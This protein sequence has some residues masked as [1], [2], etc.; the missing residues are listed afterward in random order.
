MCPLDVCRPKLVQWLHGVIGAREVLL[1]H[2][3][4]R[5]VLSH[6][7]SMAATAQASYLP[8]TRPTGR[9]AG[10]SQGSLTP[11]RL[12]ITRCPR[13]AFQMSPCQNWVNGHP[14]PEG[15]RERGS[16]GARRPRGRAQ[17]CL[18]WAS[19]LR[20]PSVSPL[21]AWPGLFPAH[22]RLDWPQDSWNRAVNRGTSVTPWN[23]FKG[24]PT[25]H[26]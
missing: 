11:E 14:D 6:R 25:S 5:V 8:P 19:D 7:C 23:S 26:L 17:C 10:G 13:R 1:L 15:Q 21:G 12:I 20:T 22:V 24:W 4:Q 18:R 16:G 3:P 2:R 9:Q